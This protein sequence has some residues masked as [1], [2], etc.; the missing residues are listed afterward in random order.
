MC[1]PLSSN[2][3][4]VDRATHAYAGRVSVFFAPVLDHFHSVV[5]TQVSGTPE[6]E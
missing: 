6:R 5:D 3:V 4:I 2:G 1:C